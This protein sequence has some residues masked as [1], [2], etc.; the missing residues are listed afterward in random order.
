M[1]YWLG[2]ALICVAL[3]AC[4]PRQDKDDRLLADGL[5]G[6][7]AGRA[8]DGLADTVRIEGSRLTWLRDGNPDAE[9]EGL[10]RSLTRTRAG[11]AGGLDRITGLV[12][13]YRRSDPQ[14]EGGMVRLRDTYRA[15]FEAGSRRF[16]HLELI[17]REVDGVP[18]LATPRLYGRLAPCASD[19][20]NQIAVNL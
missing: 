14:A 2:L 7:D 9:G 20:A 10:V 12:W 16:L 13:S 4:V 1:R 18:V 17:A 6:W 11:E 19:R 15:R 3:A 8:C 5:W